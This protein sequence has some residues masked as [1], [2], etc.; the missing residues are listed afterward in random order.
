[1]VWKCATLGNC[2]RNV[3]VAADDAA[4]VAQHA[5]DAAMLPVALLLLV[6]ELELP[7]QVVALSL[8]A[9]LS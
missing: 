8:L 1:M 9:P 5:H 6:R 4:A 7:Q 3:A 2:S